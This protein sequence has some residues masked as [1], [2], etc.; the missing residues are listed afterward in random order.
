MTNAE[1]SEFVGVDAENI[2]AITDAAKIL[3]YFKA[4]F[5]HLIE[6]SVK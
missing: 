6:M 3:W 4:S 5:Q 1:K 2:V